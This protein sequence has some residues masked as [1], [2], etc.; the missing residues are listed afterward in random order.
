MYNLYGIVVY[1]Y[2]SV[3]ISNLYILYVYVYWKYM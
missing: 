2:V 3:Y 1:I